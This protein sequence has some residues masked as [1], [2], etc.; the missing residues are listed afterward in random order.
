MRWGSGLESSPDPCK[1]DILGMQQL[2]YCMLGNRPPC[3]RGCSRLK[4]QLNTYEALVPAAAIEGRT[5]SN[6]L[7]R[8]RCHKVASEA[9]VAT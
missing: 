1:N 2:C 9:A 7:V 5:T 6:S 4:N 8:S 3:L